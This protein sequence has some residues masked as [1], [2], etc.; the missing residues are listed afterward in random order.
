MAQD[1]HTFIDVAMPFGERLSS[2]YVQRVAQFIGRH[3]ATKGIKL[4][5]YQ[6]D[7]VGVAP[8]YEQA[9]AHFSSVQA[10]LSCL[11]LPL[12][13]HKMTPP[14]RVIQWLGIILDIDK[15]T[16]YIPK[17]KISQTLK[18]MKQMHGWSFMSRRHVQ[19][20]AGRINHLA[21]TCRPARLFM[22]RIL[23][24]FRGHPPWAT[25][26]SEGTRADIRWFLQY[27]PTFNGVSTMPAQQH[28]L[29]I[30]ADSC[31]VGGGAYDGHRCYTHA[32]TAEQVEDAT[33]PS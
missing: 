4:L 12:V 25:P 26:I 30:Q 3:L 9:A 22:S 7:L 15:R 17:E 24:Y 6:D 11:R 5:I 33:S 1:G 29:V 32:Y 28:S 13:K 20:L 23:A 18:E 27:L 16:L 31:M 14:T 21:E 10:L 2:L 8:T 19:S